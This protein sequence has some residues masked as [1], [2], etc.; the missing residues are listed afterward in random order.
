MSTQAAA[1]LAQKGDMSVFRRI[2][3]S[4]LLTNRW[5]SGTDPSATALGFLKIAAKTP[6]F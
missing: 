5:A 2:A 1:I 4:R 6:N 3:A